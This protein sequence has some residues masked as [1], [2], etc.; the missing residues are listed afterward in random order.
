MGLLLLQAAKK[1]TP[2]MPTDLSSLAAVAGIVVAVLALASFLGGYFA[3]RKQVQKI[4]F[5][6]GKVTDALPDLAT[7]TQLE[8]LSDNI[9]E[10][11]LANERLATKGQ[12]EDLVKNT[13]EA[14]QSLRLTAQEFTGVLTIITK[15][16]A[17]VSE[18]RRDVEILKSKTRGV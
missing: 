13:G 12:L 8:K 18:L 11:K 1:P 7:K 15:T 3:L 10:L 9:Q 6:L 16:Q 14:V 17:E 4:D 2:E 5:S